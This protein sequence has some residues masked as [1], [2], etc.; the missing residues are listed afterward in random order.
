MGW[1]VGWRAEVVVVHVIL[2]EVVVI[3]REFLPAELPRGFDLRRAAR[4]G[5]LLLRRL[6]ALGWFNGAG[7]RDARPLG[8]FVEVVIRLD[9]GALGAAW[10]ILLVVVGGDL[11]V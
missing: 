8:V 2:L 7:L 9:S 1:G 11:I 10:S 5:R 6:R 3:V 4:R